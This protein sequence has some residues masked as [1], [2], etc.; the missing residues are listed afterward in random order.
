M[1]YAVGD[2]I[3][4][5]DYN[6]LLNNTASGTP[7]AGVAAR[8]INYIA[9]T[10]AGTYGLGQTELNSVGTADT[11]TAAQWN[12]LFTVMNNIQNH[13]NITALTSTTA[14]AAGDVI[15]LKSALTTDL[16]ALAS[17]ISD[18][19]GY[20]PTALTTSGVLQ[21]STTTGTWYGSLTSAFTITFTNA[22]Q[23]RWFFNAGGRVRIVPARTGN[24]NTAG[25]ANAKDTA[26][27]AMY[28]A[29]GN[30]DIG[31]QNSTR[32]GSGE[33]LTTNGLALGFHDLT[34][35]DQTIIKLTDDTAP[36]TANT[37]EVKARLDAAVGTAVGAGVD[38]AVGTAV[39]SGVDAVVGAEVI[40]IAVSEE[41]STSIGA[42]LVV[43]TGTAIRVGARVMEGVLVGAAVAAGEGVD[44]TLALEVSTGAGVG[45]MATVDSITATACAGA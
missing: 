13:T 16:N 30:F 36:Y 17:K 10:G 18:V 38:T 22:N 7:N 44:A 15:A 34:T 11:I 31:A 3:S 20:I 33:T 43:D 6:G 24:G 39:G 21:T 32:S 41:S 5:S 14:A 42:G 29:V 2:T 27:S 25:S 4:N 26:W 35:S 12:S 19:N 9:G 28:T 1:A 40:S 37:F 23:M 8:G 45:V